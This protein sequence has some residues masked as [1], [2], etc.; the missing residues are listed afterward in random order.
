MKNC[1]IITRFEV[2]G[3]LRNREWRLDLGWAK[4]VAEVLGM[5]VGDL[6]RNKCKIYEDLNDEI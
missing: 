2:P 3:E 6:H 5:G 4:L 1:I